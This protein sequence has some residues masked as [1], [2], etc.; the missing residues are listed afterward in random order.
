MLPNEIVQ[1]F[2]NMNEQKATLPLWLALHY[3]E[4]LAVLPSRA[5]I[6]APP[7]SVTHSSQ[8]SPTQAAVFAPS[9]VSPLS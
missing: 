8:A 3:Q 1:M 6:A 4:R 7:V 5:T 2:G 9:V